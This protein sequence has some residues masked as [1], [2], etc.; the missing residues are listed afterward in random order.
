MRNA[1]FG[2]IV[3]GLD[4]AAAG[5]AAVQGLN[6]A[7]LRVIDQPEGVSADADHM[8]KHDA[9]GRRR[10]DRGIHRAAALLEDIEC[11]IGPKVMS[12]GNHAALRPAYRA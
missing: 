2:G 7:G 3:A 12:R 1:G 11:G 8:R 9:E 10:A 5:A 6:L 4:V